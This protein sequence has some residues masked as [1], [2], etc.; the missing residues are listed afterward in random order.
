MASQSIERSCI[1]VIGKTG[2]EMGG[3]EFSKIIGLESNIAP[4]V[5]KEVCKR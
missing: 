4:Q 1:H 5:F 3:S 2:N